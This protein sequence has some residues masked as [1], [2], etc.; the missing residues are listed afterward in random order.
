MKQPHGEKRFPLLCANNC[1]KLHL[2]L[3]GKGLIPV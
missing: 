2:C 1:F 3:S